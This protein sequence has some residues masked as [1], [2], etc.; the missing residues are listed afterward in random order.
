MAA[1][2]EPPARIGPGTTGQSVIVPRTVNPHRAPAEPTGTGRTSLEAT[3]S[4]PTVADTSIEA[5]PG[6]EAVTPGVADRRPLLGPEGL[7]RAGIAIACAPIVASVGWAIANREWPAGDRSIMGVYTQDVF[8]RHTPLLGTVSTMSSYAEHGQ[9]QSVHHL[10]PAQFWALSIPN[11]ILRGHPAGILIGALLVNCGA[12]ILTALFVRRRLGITAA[13]GAVLMCTILAYGL[14][15]SLLRDVWT[16]FL[17]LWPLLALV[18]L[19]WSLLD[20]DERA[21]PWTALVSGFLAQIELMFVGPAAVLTVAGLIGF[22]VRRR[23]DQRAYR[24]AVSTTDAAGEPSGMDTDGRMPAD[25]SPVDPP[26]R[27]PALGRTIIKCEIIALFMWWPVVYQEI[28]G[29]PG[30][31]TLLIRALRH[32]TDKAGAAFVRHNLVAQLQV[33]PVWVRRV[34]SPFAVGQQPSALAV[35]S[36]AVFTA[37]LVAVTVSSWR[38]RR[39]QP[40]VFALVVT[41][42]PVLL[43]AY[44]NLSITPLKGTVGLQYRRWLWPF[45]AFLWFAVIVGALSWAAD[46]SWSTAVRAKARPLTVGLVFLAL[47]T[48]VVIPASISQLTPPSDDVRA[49]KEVESMW[50]PLHERLAKKSTYLAVGGAD[51]AFGVGPEIMRRLIVAGY[52]MRTSTFGADSYGTQR[53]LSARHPAKQTINLITGVTTLAPSDQPISLLAAGTAD[54]SSADEYVKFVNVLLPRLRT[55]GGFALDD[56]GLAKQHDQMSQDGDPSLQRVTDLLAD[57]TRAMFDA[58]LLRLQLDGHTTSSPLSD[59]EARQLLNG[60]NKVSV[61][62]F[63]R[64]APD[65]PKS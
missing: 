24:S 3:S 41:A 12:V 18:V 27:P 13:T 39:S 54:G 57:P 65:I 33:P 47:A 11:L 45:G 64:G 10:G 22:I 59:D 52:P 53:V 25:G 9:A 6:P 19:A 5:T 8:T 46:R 43:A 50:G 30:N 35:G 60:M 55:D 1:P 48:V 34:T 4:E 61:L 42:Y 40:T 7:F 20:G 49:N 31:L 32:P 62:A 56:A 21:L 17:G 2:D 29:H 44:V 37:L 23:A 38:R 26:T 63:L 36:A 58:N 16:P 15:P 14:G 51:A 28:T